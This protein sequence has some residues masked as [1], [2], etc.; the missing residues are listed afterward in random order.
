L[1][2]S[3]AQPLKKLQAK[4]TGKRRRPRKKNVNLPLLMSPTPKE[5]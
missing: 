1:G 5:L 3:A 4:T 2:F